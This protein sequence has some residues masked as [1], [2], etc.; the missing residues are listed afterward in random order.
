MSL[1][2]I[3]KFLLSNCTHKPARSLK[4][5]ACRHVTQVSH[6]RKDSLFRQR[7]GLLTELPPVWRRCALGTNHIAA[8][9]VWRI[10]RRRTAPRLNRCGETRWHLCHR[11]VRGFPLSANP[12]QGAII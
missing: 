12:Q 7:R 10:G 1:V 3:W 9:G 11:S 5:V 8:H 2:S 4:A 6:R